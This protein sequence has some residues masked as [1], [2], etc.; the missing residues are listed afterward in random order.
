ML[1]FVSSYLEARHSALTK[2][3]MA[4]FLDPGTQVGPLKSDML[5]VAT[6]EKGHLS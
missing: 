5:L 4:Q 3:I 6:F 2:P 1:L